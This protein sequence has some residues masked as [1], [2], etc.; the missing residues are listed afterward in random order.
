V[1]RATLGLGEVVA[2]PVDAVVLDF[3]DPLLEAPTVRVTAPD[4]GALPV[5]TSL[6]ADDVAR[7]TVGPL[8]EPGPCDVAYEYASLDGAPQQGAHR[9]ELVATTSDGGIELRSALAVAMAVLLVGLAGRA[10]WARRRQ[11]R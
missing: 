4:G 11:T 1:Q 7:T 10:A 3:L 5:T 6:T 9:F 2:A 8:T